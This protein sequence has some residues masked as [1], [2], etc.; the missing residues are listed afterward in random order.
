M[1]SNRPRA[2]SAA[3]NAVAKAQV[4]SVGGGHKDATQ[5][6]PIAKGPSQAL[7]P[8][9]AGMYMVASQAICCAINFSGWNAAA[10]FGWP[11][12]MIAYVLATLLFWTLSLSIAEMSCGLPF[13]G[14]PATFAQAAFGQVPFHGAVEVSAFSA[15]TFT[16]AYCS[17]IAW[18]ASTVA[19]Y[20]A[21]L[22]N[23]PNDSSNLQPILWLLLIEAVVLTNF[24]P[25]VYFRI[26]VFFALFNFVVLAAYTLFSLGHVSMIQTSIFAATQPITMYNVLQVLPYAI[27]FYWGVE[28]LCLTA[29]ECHDITKCSPRATLATMSALTVV[30]AMSM[31]LNCG[32]MPSLDALVNSS[33]AVFDSFFYQSGVSSTSTTS[34]ALCSLILAIQNSGWLHGTLYAASRHTYSLARAG[35]LPVQLSHTRN[36]SP[37]NATLACAAVGY[38]FSILYYI[39][40]NTGADINSILL[41]VTT[42]LLCVSYMTE[43]VVFVRLRYKMRHLPRPFRS[44]VGVPGAL[45]GASVTLL[46]IFGPF[47]L[48]PF[49][50]GCMFA[51]YFGA[52]ALFMVYYHLFA[53]TRLRNSP[54]KEFIA[55]VPPQSFCA[56]R[57]TD[58]CSSTTGQKSSAQLKRLYQIKVN[59]HGMSTTGNSHV[60]NTGGR[61]V[62]KPANIKATADAQV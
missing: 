9:I 22:F 57:R 46:S 18:A 14:G 30:S 56:R 40:A 38:V 32:L 47:A 10:G 4:A 8:G 60:S 58:L 61:P 2:P 1:T 15:I 5:S 52:M 37:V 44:P 33:Q 35:Y 25:R 19:G 3:L 24:R 31:W 17:G 41:T 23:F 12:F 21:T 28:T 20:I 48:D 13:T 6:L 49:T 51:V 53:K 16:V 39:L 29:E 11:N 34:V 27:Y 55:Y 62:S 50:T 7:L 36:G 45:A 59:E 43:L 42:W 54:E 26:C